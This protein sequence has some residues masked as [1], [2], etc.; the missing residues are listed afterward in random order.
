MKNQKCRKLKWNQIR[1]EAVQQYEATH[2]P[3]G[4]AARCP[5]EEKME[6]PLTQE[7]FATV[8]KEDFEWLSKFKWHA[9][10][11]GRTWY[12]RRTVESEGLQK[13]DFM[14]R[15]ILAHHGHDLTVGEVDHIN[16]DGLDNRKSNLQVISHAENI[17]KSRTQSNNTSGFR[18][19]SWHKRDQVWSAF[20][21][22]NNVRKYLG[23]FK[24]KINA[25]LAYDEAARKYF[26]EFAKLN[27]PLLNSRQ[28]NADESVRALNGTVPEAY[29]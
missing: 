25:A 20:I 22:V 8:D 28:V 10:K 19:V 24:S 9:H 23:S 27:L 3:I 16:G 4:S 5:I 15:A 13:T 29:A 7:R 1:R 11:R 18:G 6:I 21:E 12:A 26:G 2:Y 17:R 14:H